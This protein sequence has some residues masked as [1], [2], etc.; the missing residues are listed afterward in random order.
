[1][2]KTCFIKINSQIDIEDFINKVPIPI[3]IPPNI[4]HVAIPGPYFILHFF[5]VEII[6]KINIVIGQ[7]LVK[8]IFTYNKSF[9]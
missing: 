6:I 3:I 8:K 1:L 4:P 9:A 2:I 5:L 7:I